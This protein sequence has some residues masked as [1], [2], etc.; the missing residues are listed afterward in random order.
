MG[1]ELPYFKFIANEWLTGD[2]AFE[3]YD[4]QGL[5]IIV[6]STYWNR[7]CSITLAML[8]QRLSNAREELWQCLIDGGYITVKGNQISIK[9]LDEQFSDLKQAHDKR[10]NA[11]R[12]GGNAKAMLEQSPSI[13]DKEEDTD[14]IAINSENTIELRNCFTM[15]ESVAKLIGKSIDQIDELLDLFITEQKAKGEMNRSLGDLRR[16]FTSWAKINHDKVKRSN[17]GTRN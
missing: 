11:G 7:D 2:I 12:K 9:F 13:L 3:E 17:I 4:V 15:K 16:H 10:V 1:K 8:K 5:F 6:C 14:T